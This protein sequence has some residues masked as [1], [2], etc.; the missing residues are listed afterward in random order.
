MKKCLLALTVIFASL[1]LNA[2]PKPPNVEN[3]E[4]YCGKLSFNNSKHDCLAVTKD[5]KFFSSEAIAVCE[6]VDF[7]NN[8]VPCIK[9]IKDKTFSTSVL[10]ICA[11]E[12]FDNKIVDCL[13]KNGRPYEAESRE[14]PEQ[15]EE[16]PASLRK[17]LEKAL[18]ELEMGNEK[19]AKKIIKEILRDMR[20]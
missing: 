20:D 3:A 7:D 17:R 2:I 12:S 4:A 15:P 8:K 1:P 11:D 16:K 19:K 5:A 6:G 14:R 18:V 9:A 13:S 10:K